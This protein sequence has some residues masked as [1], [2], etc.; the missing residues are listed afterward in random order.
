MDGERRRQNGRAP[1]NAKTEG[2]MLFKAAWN[3]TT[4]RQPNVFFA[5]M[6]TAYCSGEIC[7]TRRV[8]SELKSD[9]GVAREKASVQ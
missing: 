1:N 5:R 8:E 2:A 7:E 4:I 6:R 3:S 9:R